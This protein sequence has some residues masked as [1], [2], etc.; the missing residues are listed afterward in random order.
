MEGEFK[1]NNN[2]DRAFKWLS[3]LDVSALMEPWNVHN[4]CNLNGLKQVIFLYH[5]PA[6]NIIYHT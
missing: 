2:L 5:K 4:P 1:K 3:L 6:I